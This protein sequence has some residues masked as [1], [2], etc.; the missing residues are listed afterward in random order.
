MAAARAAKTPA[1]CPPNQNATR[2]PIPAAHV[3]HANKSDDP[4]ARPDLST[5]ADTRATA[6][7]RPIHNSPLAYSPLTYYP[8]TTHLLTTH[9][10]TTHHSLLNYSPLTTHHSPLTNPNSSFV[11]QT[12]R[13]AS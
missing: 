1:K 11:A 10:S 13:D 5:H 2:P 3:I 6:P 8:L 9:H 4:H 12:Y 7:G